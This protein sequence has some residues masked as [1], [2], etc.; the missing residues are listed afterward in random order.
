MKKCKKARGKK[1]ELTLADELAKF[2]VR[3]RIVCRRLNALTINRFLKLTENKV[4]GLKNAGDITWDSI[5]RLQE[6]LRKQKP[7][8]AKKHKITTKRKK[9]DAKSVSELVRN[10]AKLHELQGVLINKL[11]IAGKWEI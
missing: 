11:Q 3:A 2:P 1:K 10:L 4:R 6:K 5:R 7:K 9:S 8:V